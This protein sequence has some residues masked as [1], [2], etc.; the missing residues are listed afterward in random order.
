MYYSRVPATV[1]IEWTT[2]PQITTW[3]DLWWPMICVTP[4]VFG[5]LIKWFWE[6]RRRAKF[7]MIFGAL[8][9]AHISLL[10]AVIPIIGRVPTLWLVPF[11]IAEGVLLLTLIAR[12][13]GDATVPP[14][15]RQTRKIRE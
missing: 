12:V 15:M 13:L 14:A 5:M 4:I 10:W 8:L 3:L 9:L 6:Q 11:A 7:W 1:I 2:R